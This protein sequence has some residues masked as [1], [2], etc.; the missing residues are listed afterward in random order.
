MKSFCKK[1]D[2]NFNLFSINWILSSAVDKDLVKKTAA[3]RSANP[4][5]H[6]FVYFSNIFLRANLDG[7]KRKKCTINN[8]F[9]LFLYKMNGWK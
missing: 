3:T 7:G 4:R 5:L 8:T 2:V 9:T 6:V 1:M